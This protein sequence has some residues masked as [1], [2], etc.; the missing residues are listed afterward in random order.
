MVVAGGRGQRDE[1]LQRA[2]YGD[3]A[4]GGGL[5]ALALVA[6]EQGDAERFVKTRGKGCE[7]SMVTGV[8]RG[9]T[10]LA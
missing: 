7:G 4:E 6:Q 1:A 10:S 2:R 9:S 5:V 8:R 3:D